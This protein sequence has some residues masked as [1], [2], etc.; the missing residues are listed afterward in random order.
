MKKNSILIL[1]FLFY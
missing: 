1:F